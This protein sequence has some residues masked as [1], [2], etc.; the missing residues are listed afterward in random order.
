MEQAVPYK[1][2]YIRLRYGWRR[3]Q[4]FVKY[5][6]LHVDD[7]PHRIALGVAI[8]M[9]VAWTPTIGFQMGLTVLLCALFRANK[10]VGV[11]LVWISNPLT[12]IPVYFVFTRSTIAVPP[13]WKADS[14]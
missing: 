3:A 7:T 5:R 14:R 2:M 1:Y 9:F 10:L 8:G 4:R 13:R 6:I 11:P 12:I